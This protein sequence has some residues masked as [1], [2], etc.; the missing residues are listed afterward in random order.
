[1]PQKGIFDLLDSW[2]HTVIQ[3]TAF[4]CQMGMDFGQNKLTQNKFS[5]LNAVPTM[6]L[7]TMSHF[8]NILPQNL[9]NPRRKEKEGS[10][11]FHFGF[12]R[13]EKEVFISQD[14]QPY[15]SASSNCMPRSHGFEMLFFEIPLRSYKSQGN[16]SLTWIF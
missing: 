4:V 12:S 5:V 6:T 2:S 15:R 1:M 8:D 16:L 7:H 13:A 14:I 11:C 10:F 9:R 3:A